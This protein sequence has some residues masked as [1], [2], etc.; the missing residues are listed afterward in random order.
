M[1]EL[2]NAL[3]DS[4]AAAQRTKPS[5]GMHAELL[6]SAAVGAVME[7]V[8]PKVILQ[9]LWTDGP[10]VIAAVVSIYNE[11]KSGAFNWSTWTTEIEKYGK[12][13]VT[14]I[15]DIASKFNVTLPAVPPS[16]VTA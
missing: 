9:L 2:K 6:T 12:I 1:S 3:C 13:F 10:T 7:A 11:I 8:D 15:Q 4:L 14:I 5:E 16:I